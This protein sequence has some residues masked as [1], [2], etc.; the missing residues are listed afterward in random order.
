MV[1]EKKLTEEQIEN[2]RHYLIDHLNKYTGKKK[3][4]INIDPKILEKVIFEY[5]KNKKSTYKIFALPHN[6]IKELDLSDISF[7][8]FKVNN[9]DFEGFYGVKLNPQT[10]YKRDFAYSVLKG[11]EIT[12]P[13]DNCCVHATDFTESKG[14]KLNPQKVHKRD[15]D[16]STLKGVEITGPLDNCSIYATDFT[17]SIGATMNYNQFIK[18]E[19]CSILTDVKINTQDL[20]EYFEKI[21]EAFKINEELKIN[22][23]PKRKNYKKRKKEGR[24]FK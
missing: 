14:A 18:Y 22:D 10:V 19:K 7:D 13:F 4:K 11:V 23:F 21:N 16:Y 17:G 6:L 12:G 2:L 8:D 3:I 5:E 15:L 24:K 20:E 1:E 9:F